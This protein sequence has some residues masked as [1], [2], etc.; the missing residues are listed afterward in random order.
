MA[1]ETTTVK[2]TAQA[3]AE[4][5]QVFGKPKA[6]EFDATAAQASRFRD[7]VRRYVRDRVQKSVLGAG[8]IVLSVV[9]ARAAGITYD[10]DKYGTRELE[11]LYRFAA[12]VVLG[13]ARDVALGFVSKV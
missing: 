1:G 7:A 2:K 4:W 12:E 13:I 9:G 11:A 6:R 3:E 5:R 8:R 10:V